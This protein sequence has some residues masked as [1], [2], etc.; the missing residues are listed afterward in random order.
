MPCGIWT[1]CYH[2]NAWSQRDLAKFEDDI[3]S[4][5]ARIVSASEGVM[6]AHT[7]GWTDHLLSRLWLLAIQ[8]KRFLPK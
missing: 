1:I 5:Q 4:F 2:H 7:Y 8:A 3:Q 6:E